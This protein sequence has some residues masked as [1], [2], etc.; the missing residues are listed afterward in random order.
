MHVHIA[1]KSPSCP[2]QVA[3]VAVMYFVCQVMS[4]AMQAAHL[5]SSSLR[6]PEQREC[7]NPL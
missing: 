1:P 5:F 3:R 4:V 2:A 6:W 7:F